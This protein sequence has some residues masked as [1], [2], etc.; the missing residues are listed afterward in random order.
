MNFIE[1]LTVPLRAETIYPVVSY[2]ST[3]N[4]ILKLDPGIHIF[5][6]QEYGVDSQKG[7]E[8]S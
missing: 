8:R 5:W 3:L 1:N 7:K 6:R 4:W 2:L